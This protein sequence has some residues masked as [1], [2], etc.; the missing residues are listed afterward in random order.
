MTA[1]DITAY[2]LNKTRD[3]NPAFEQSIPFGAAQNKP[4]PSTDNHRGPTVDGPYVLHDGTINVLRGS[5]EEEHLIIAA[6]D[7]EQDIRNQLIYALIYGH[8]AAEQTHTEL[9]TFNSVQ[10]PDL[11]EQFEFPTYFDVNQRLRNRVL[12]SLA[13]TAWMTLDKQRGQL[14]VIAAENR[15]IALLPRVIF[16]AITVVYAVKH[17]G[18]WALIPVSVQAPQIIVRYRMQQRA[19]SLRTRVVGYMSQIAVVLVNVRDAISTGAL[20]V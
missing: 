8:I 20:V 9:R 5:H 17:T 16:A 14:E 19:L 18:W 6:P 3:L 2:I 11:H 10:P 1:L 12:I 15:T 7:P 4:V 13:R